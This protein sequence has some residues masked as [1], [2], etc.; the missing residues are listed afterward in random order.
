MQ[1]TIGVSMLT[2]D[3][4]DDM[5]KIKAFPVATSSSGGEP[6]IN[7]VGLLKIIDDQTIWMV[8]NFMDKTLSNLKERPRASFLVWN[9]DTK[10]AWQVKGDVEI[11]SSGEDYQKAREWA[12]SLRD[13]LPAKN[14]LVMKVTEVYNVKSGPDAGKRIV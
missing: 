7:V 9:A 6:N 2:Q 5:G 14:L 1:T 10:G 4:K 13:T 11:V 12:H 3:V 8:D